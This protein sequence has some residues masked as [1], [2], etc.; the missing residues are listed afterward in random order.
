[1]TGNE[2]QMA[3]WAANVPWGAVLIG[4]HATCMSAIFGHAAWKSRRARRRIMEGP[5]WTLRRNRRYSRS[6]QAAK[7]IKRNGS[8]RHGR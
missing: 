1:M 4:F 2:P 6:R 3:A 8:K 5:E 7:A